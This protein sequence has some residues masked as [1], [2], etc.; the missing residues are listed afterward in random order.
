MPTAP[1]ARVGCSGWQYKHWR[2]AF[3]PADLPASQWFAYYA[4]QFDTVEINN[5]FYRLPE[6][7]TFAAWRKQATPGFLYAVKASRFLTHMKKLKDPAEPLHRLFQRAQ[8]LQRTFGPVLYQLPPHWTVNLERLSAFVRAL[9]KRRQHVIE[10]REPSW[11]NDEVFELL[12]RTASRSASTIWRDR[13][14]G[15]W[16]SARSFMCAFTG[17]PNT[18]VATMT[19]I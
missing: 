17:P 14:P 10:F 11:Y 7:S 3:Y 13:G 18:R 4:S 12:D 2:G 15:K 8:R 5:T 19:V 6:A 16:W 9:P 1:S